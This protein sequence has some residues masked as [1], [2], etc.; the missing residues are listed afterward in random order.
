LAPES[1]RVN[2]AASEEI[3]YPANPARRGAIP[4]SKIPVP[5]YGV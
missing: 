5:G 1:S 2:L 3:A 4:L